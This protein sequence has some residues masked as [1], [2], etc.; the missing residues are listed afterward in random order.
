MEENII[1]LYESL[2]GDE[3]FGGIDGFKVGLEDE[4]NRLKAYESVGGDEKFGDFK[5]FNDALGFGGPTAEEQ[6]A[7][8]TERL[9]G[10]GL[11][12]MSDIDRLANRF[13][14]EEM[15]RQPARD[16]DEPSSLDNVKAVFDWDF[17][18]NS[19][20]AGV[21]SG[22][23]GNMHEIIENQLGPGEENLSDDYFEKY[24]ALKQEQRAIG[25]GL[26]EGRGKERNAGRFFS[27]AVSGFISS[28]V[29]MAA[30]LWEDWDGVGETVAGLLLSPLT[31]G[32]S[33][34]LVMGHA[35]ADV[36]AGSIMDQRIDEYGAEH[37]I[38]TSTPEGLREV[39]K[40]EEY[41][42]ES[43]KKAAIGGMIVGAAEAL[44]GIV[45]SKV[46]LK[47]VTSIKGIKDVGYNVMGR[48][49]I[50]MAFDGTGEVAKQLVV[51]GKVDA[52][53]V[54]LEVVTPG[55]GP[56]LGNVRATIGD[57]KQI[58]HN[59]TRTELIQSGEIRPEGGDNAT[60]SSSIAND[61]E[62]TPDEAAQD[63]LAPA[64]ESGITPE[65]VEKNKSEVAKQPDPNVSPEQ[66]AQQETTDKLV[67][68]LGVEKASEAM[69]EAGQAKKERVNPLR[70]QAVE[71]G[72][73]DGGR[74][75]ETIADELVKRGSLRESQKGLITEA[76]G[77]VRKAIAS[78]PAEIR[79]SKD[80]KDQAKAREI[81]QS[82]IDIDTQE[83]IVANKQAE[84]DQL[85][86]ELAGRAKAKLAK[87]QVK[88]EKMSVGL[89]NVMENS[90]ITLEDYDL[91]T[92]LL[93]N[94]Q[95]NDPQ[96]Y[97]LPRV[98]LD[99]QNNTVKLNE[100]Y[101]EYHPA[102]VATIDAYNRKNPDNQVTIESTPVVENKSDFKFD[103]NS[104]IQTHQSVTIDASS[105]GRNATISFNDTKATG[106]KD[107]VLGLREQGLEARTQE[108]GALSEEQSNAWKALVDEGYAKFN[109]NTGYTAL[110]EKEAETLRETKL[111]EEGQEFLAVKRVQDRRNER[112]TVNRL[113]SEVV[114]ARKTL[115]AVNPNSEVVL[116]SNEEFVKQ[117]GEEG[118]GGYIK[119]KGR[120]TIYINEDSATATTVGHELAHAILQERHNMTPLSLMKIHQTIK[121]ALTLG[122][123][124]TPL[125]KDE[126]ALVNELEKFIA[127]YDGV[128]EGAKAE[129][130]IVELAA[131]LSANGERI[132]QRP[133]LTRTIIR[134]IN[135]AVRDLTGIKGAIKDETDINEAINFVNGLADQ[136]SGEVVVEDIAL[137]E[138]STIT[139]TTTANT[140]SVV[141]DEQMGEFVEMGHIDPA[142]I[143]GLN[144]KEVGQIPLT[145]NEKI[146]REAVTFH[147]QATPNVTNDV[148]T[149][150]NHEGESRV[151]TD[152]TKGTSDSNT[153]FD[154][155][156]DIQVQIGSTAISG[157][158]MRGGNTLD[159][160]VGD[161]RSL[162][163]N[164]PEVVQKLDTITSPTN[165]GNLKITYGKA[166]IYEV[167]RSQ[168]D[169]MSQI[170]IGVGMK[171]HSNRNGE[172]T[173]RVLIPTEAVGRIDAD[174]LS[175]EA[176]RLMDKTFVGDDGKAAKGTGEKISDAKIKTFQIGLNDAINASMKTDENNPVKTDLSNLEYDDFVERGVVSDDTINRIANKLKN[177]TA[178]T[179]RETAIFSNK[180][181]E[182]NEALVEEYKSEP[183]PPDTTTQ[184]Q[185]K[186][187]LH[188]NTDV[189][190]TPAD[191]V[192][193]ISGL[194][195]E[196]L[197][198][199]DE[200]KP[201]IESGM[202]T[203]DKTIADFPGK[204][205]FHTP[206]RMFGGSV[207]NK[208][209]KTLIKGEGGILYPIVNAVKG[210]K[211]VWA[212][213]SQGAT[214]KFVDQL[215]D[216]AKTSP[217]GSASLFINS[218]NS[219]KTRSSTSAIRGGLNTAKHILDDIL[220]FSPKETAEFFN[221]VQVMN[222]RTD[223]AGVVQKFTYGIEGD[224]FFN[225]AYEQS[226]PELS[227]FDQRKELNNNIISTLAKTL[228][229]RGEK[230][231]A[232]AS[233][234]VGKDDIRNTASPSGKD[235][236]A[237]ID[238]ILAENTF[239][240][241]PAGYMYAVVQAIPKPGRDPSLPL[242]RIN[243]DTDR[244]ASYNW[245]VDPY[246][247]DVEVKVHFLK[248]QVHY[249][250]AFLDSNGNSLFQDTNN[251]KEL[252]AH[253]NYSKMKT[254]KDKAAYKEGLGY[255]KPQFIQLLSPNA[256]ITA[257]PQ[258]VNTG[259]RPINIT[260]GT[261]FKSEKLIKA[262]TAYKKH[263]SNGD[264]AK[265]LSEYK[266]M[267][268]A[269]HNVINGRFPSLP[270]TINGANFTTSTTNVDQFSGN[271]KLWRLGD[272]LKFNLRFDDLTGD[273]EAVVLELAELAGMGEVN[274]LHSGKVDMDSDLMSENSDG[275][276]NTTGFE[277]KFKDDKASASAVKTLSQKYNISGATI[278]SNGRLVITNNDTNQ[279]A[280]KASAK[281][282]INDN[283]GI[284][285]GFRDT[286]RRVSKYSKVDGR[287]ERFVGDRAVQPNDAA[288]V[289]NAPKRGSEFRS[290][291]VSVF[292]K[293][294][295]VT[296]DVVLDP[297]SV[298]EVTKGEVDARPVFNEFFSRMDERGE[299]V[300]L[301]ISEITTPEDRWDVDFYK[302]FG[303]FISPDG[304]TLSR[305]VNGARYIVDGTEGPA[306]KMQ[307][308]GDAKSV[309]DALAQ[310]I[311][312]DPH[313]SD[314]KKAE[315]LKKFGLTKPPLTNSRPAGEPINNYTP[316]DLSDAEKASGTF[317][318]GPLKMDNA[319][320]NRYMEKILG[321]SLKLKG[322]I[323]SFKEQ[324]KIA[325]HRGY[326]DEVGNIGG[327]T[328][329]ILAK[330]TSG[331]AINNY[332]YI[333]LMSAFGE[334]KA[335][336]A[337]ARDVLENA[338]ISGILDRQNQ[339]NLIADYENK[340]QA[341]G[342][343]MRV[344]KTIY[345]RGLQ[346]NSIVQSASISTEADFADF[347]RKYGRSVD[348]SLLAEVEQA[349]GD[350]K[351]A[352]EGLESARVE[353][354]NIIK[355][356]KERRV[357]KAIADAKNSSPIKNAKQN[358][359]D[360]FTRKFQLD[361]DIRNYGEEAT[362]QKFEAIYRL[363]QDILRNNP[364]IN[365]LAELEAEVS[366]VYGQITNPQ[367]TFETDDVSIALDLSLEDSRKSRTDKLQ[368]DLNSID[369]LL[370]VIDNIVR[371]NTA[372]NTN[373]ANGK[374]NSV[375]AI[376]AMMDA[377]GGFAN[378]LLS[379]GF[380]G[381]PNVNAQATAMQ[382]LNA[383]VASLPDVYGATQTD[384]FAKIART[385]E[386]T[387]ALIGFDT[388]SGKSD[389]SAVKKRL[390]AKLDAEKTM[391]I[392]GTTVASTYV[393][394]TRGI[395]EAEARAIIA[396][397]KVR[398][399]ERVA[400]RK[401][402]RAEADGVYEKM[403]TYLETVK[404]VGF[405]VPRQVIFS[406]DYS[407][408][409][410]QG[411][412][413][414]IGLIPRTA[415]DSIQTM[416][417][418]P[419][420]DLANFATSTLALLNPT[421][422]AGGKQL[423]TEEG[424]KQL[425]IEFQGDHVVNEMN[426]I[427]GDVFGNPL[428]GAMISDA[429]EV[430]GARLGSRIKN[431][432]ARNPQLGG[433]IGYPAGK[434]GNIFNYSANTYT[435]FMNNLRLQQYKM[436]IRTNPTAT[437][438]QKKIV[439]EGIMDMT[440][441]GVATTAA[442]NL[443]ASREMSLVLAAPRLYLSRWKVL[444]NMPVMMARLA[445]SGYNQLTGTGKNTQTTG[446]SKL[447]YA[448]LEM[449]KQYFATGLG[450]AGTYA[451]LTMM[452]W[453]W[454]DDEK[455]KNYLRFKKNDEV[456]DISA[457]MSAFIK[458]PVFAMY[459]R[460]R[461]KYGQKAADEQYGA[462]SATQRSGLNR[463][464]VGSDITSMLTYKLHPTI[465]L[466]KSYATG[467]DAIG[468]SFGQ[469]SEQEIINRFL[470]FAPISIQEAVKGTTELGESRLFKKKETTYDYNKMLTIL[471]V[472]DIH[473]END[474]KDVAVEA[475]LDV[476]KNPDSDDGKP[477][478]VP[479][480]SA[481]HAKKY[482]VGNRG[483]PPAER[484]VD[485]T[486]RKRL[487][488]DYKDDVK[489]V[490]GKFILDEL[491][492]GNEPTKKQI[493]KTRDRA[494]KEIGKAYYEKRVR[495]H[496][497]WVWDE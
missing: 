170:N 336:L 205:V 388:K 123:V 365:T 239:D 354:D 172:V 381:N 358:F 337:E 243:N 204:G 200:I 237:I 322:D 211:S 361:D 254:D 491:K 352:Q 99:V 177:N 312:S 430:V 387:V 262:N 410:M 130:F 276:Y 121:S 475:Y 433:V 429:E 459:D 87:E 368:R 208:D 156:S 344:A 36:E 285:S 484:I 423:H 2:G 14:E 349:F 12:V 11:S 146:I 439:I 203:F 465:G 319:T 53:E 228:K 472:S 15:E 375:E 111:V 482:I 94:T 226:D 462:I 103:E 391:S 13:K 97:R 98:A 251:S 75:V 90:N 332:E 300:V 18:A 258:T 249:V 33:L 138:V 56:I 428:Q 242:V 22:K 125:N 54:G 192:E 382:N 173:A 303:M 355:A 261:F 318:Y 376:N 305:G 92:Q 399:L 330:L 418:D 154:N 142:I 435:M 248:E 395:L 122:S 151:D 341:Y 133:S 291:G 44:G 293:K 486:R 384:A 46:G 478:W 95:N 174:K 67:E 327:N 431:F 495:G 238:T 308:G 271:D 440:G 489:Q 444:Q 66:V 105:K 257:A 301:N 100:D 127:A 134:A 250:N 70:D 396:M 187:Q 284:I 487:F 416:S 116:L 461:K 102:V 371:I 27:D 162:N 60:S 199:S 302:S 82:I 210:I 419:V 180:T 8:E 372:L 84:I 445:A 268:Y 414:V 31:R 467:V 247:S 9:A 47:A 441:R 404:V 42:S 131:F 339:R 147:E 378:A 483:E 150:F 65:Q 278:L 112:P 458:I 264:T 277:L 197:M 25:A 126:Q 443:V 457:G 275:S 227:S 136:I 163:P 178:L 196:N 370:P 403:L 434:I 43:K 479:Q 37:G 353:R 40:N 282:F 424:V 290:R 374:N 106:L 109:K 412:L 26:E 393:A 113:R 411:G 28:P 427:R 351:A 471:G 280:F 155:P 342:N 338:G 51:S 345:G 263:I 35:G 422:Y 119:R 49:G 45:A 324:F 437:D 476:I 19:V 409:L 128:T 307:L 477:G 245:A 315:L 346:L 79:M 389:A 218:S 157:H 206:D 357:A 80:P 215:N 216:A 39:Y 313:L 64:Q 406:V 223:K 407:F 420:V 314:A 343:A 468:R 363:T 273:V 320:L 286:S 329:R 256:G 183:T 153:V 120:S 447:D 241:V 380:P 41:I 158:R 57:V 93:R 367:Y 450:F 460:Y 117:A 77:I 58:G 452:D 135:K 115:A 61:V 366:Q 50:G 316:D 91:T 149:S 463:R 294:D 4:N 232:W 309:G 74:S 166:T 21:V 186:M 400:D 17:L 394:R 405:E 377:L 201:L 246:D 490:V 287:F 350:V 496:D 107:A 328:T 480:I 7:I 6:E 169:G 88:L 214:I 390:Q 474:F 347:R 304:S 244:H 253:T 379:E 207:K 334:V 446:T 348:V 259:A 269:L 288:R 85:K 69:S 81:V 181:G 140:T 323:Q 86:P 152:E 139:S 481:T 260:L 373:A 137:K 335:K 267:V 20:K 297:T 145:E 317:K 161:P 62:M 10:M 438:A 83:S 356:T 397:D 454:E 212:S 426:R 333:G 198:N 231:S 213:V 234:F 72:L 29:A 182:I 295:D 299:K 464:T 325:Y 494:A 466:A 266:K 230:F 34:Q 132:A 96:N 219:D 331:D 296:G 220:G 124:K 71:T 194:T 360:F 311:Q 492:A 38:D 3:K 252:N 272:D 101:K 171:D 129:E 306:I 401:K 168:D 165:F 493:E 255:F 473:Y 164:G 30:E 448:S 48:T 385:M 188:E 326:I 32:K 442:G 421:R 159:L 160:N 402:A 289:L 73:I 236:G 310:K 265:A 1:K 497:H 340:L 415:I 184:R 76:T 52:Y 108:V 222:N 224:D 167:S 143:D 104:A 359:L 229:G 417:V 369:K 321:T 469:S 392:T 451:L 221:A 202:I 193:N 110:S 279:E 485:Y 16:S 413:N 432:V 209:G 470:G 398:S 456:L 190:T 240:D 63:E 298:S 114:K 274:I 175:V 59:K 144:D 362:A 383:I 141:N 24:A 179:D 455:D 233:E 5:G 189:F 386:E 191:V 89:S 185:V 55:P 68:E 425:W 408:A 148:Q 281:Q 449:M 176:G 235:I 488:D 436:F 270:Y 283:Q 195:K 217:D 118:R 225:Q 78:I 292:F 364:A 453:D 23:I